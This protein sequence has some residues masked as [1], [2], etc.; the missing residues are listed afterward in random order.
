MGTVELESGEMHAKKT[1]GCIRSSHQDG[2]SDID[3][4]KQNRPRKQDWQAERLE[5]V[6]MSLRTAAQAQL[7]SECKKK[8]KAIVHFQVDSRCLHM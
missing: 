1:R 6:Q 3:A 8:E 4:Y 7:V 5:K 2:V